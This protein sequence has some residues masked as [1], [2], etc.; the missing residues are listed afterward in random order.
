MIWAKSP[1]SDLKKDI[2]SQCKI[3]LLKL[4]QVNFYNRLEYGG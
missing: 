1:L 2:L 4:S 3:S